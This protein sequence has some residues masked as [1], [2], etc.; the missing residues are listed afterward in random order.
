MALEGRIPAAA[1]AIV[2]ERH[3]EY[4]IAWYANVAVSARPGAIPHDL[5]WRVL[6]GNFIGLGSPLDKALMAARAE[7]SLVP[8]LGVHPRH[9]DGMVLVSE[10]TWDWVLDHVPSPVRRHFA[11]WHT[12]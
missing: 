11:A 3:I 5:R 4:M 8:P 2:P 10:T 1:T 6:P 7:P 9:P 12:K